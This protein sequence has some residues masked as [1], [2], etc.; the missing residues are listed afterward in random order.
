[1]ARNHTIREDTDIYPL[2]PGALETR[3]KKTQSGI[4]LIELLVVVA[5]VGILA[6]LAY[7]SY[8]DY[9]RRAGRAEA[10]GILLESAQFM[11]RNYTVS[12][13][14]SVDA[15]GTAIAVPF[16]QSPKSGTAKY[17]ITFA[18]GTP[19]TNTYTLQATPTGTMT[20]DTCG[21]LTLDQTGTKGAG[22]AVADCWGH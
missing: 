6:S 7:P 13:N 2:A 20:G 21:T 10:E 1:M 14:Y 16:A 15:T 4:T 17:N 5:I 18:A 19:T 11:E 9:I 22:G 3:M 12:N 8:Q